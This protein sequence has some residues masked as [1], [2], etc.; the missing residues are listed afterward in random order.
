MLYLAVLIDLQRI[1]MKVNKKTNLKQHIV[2]VK[3]SGYYA[4][5]LK[6]VYGNPVSF[7]RM[8]SEYMCIERYLVN[9]PSMTLIT[10]LCYSDMAFNYKEG[11][12]LFSLSGSTPDPEEYSQFIPIVIPDEL[13]KAGNLVPTSPSWQLSLPG[14]TK[15]RKLISRNFW[16]SFSRFHEECKF[17]AANMN[18]TCGTEAITSDFMGMYNIDMADYENLLRYWRRTRQKMQQEIEQNRELVEACTG[19]AFFYTA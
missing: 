8:S 7:P 12:G 3:V 11:N 16:M 6:T 9:N 13:M 17:R 19:N 4:Q 15:L 2:Y 10:P 1:I 14:V 5:F 18:E